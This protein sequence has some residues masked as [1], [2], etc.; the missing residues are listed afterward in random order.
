ML[1]CAKVSP[2]PRDQGILGNLRTEVYPEPPL[3]ERSQVAH[4]V[5]C[6]PTWEV[7]VHLFSQHHCIRQQR[8]SITHHAE[9]EITLSW[10]WCLTP[11]SQ[12]GKKTNWKERESPSPL[13]LS[14]LSHCSSKVMASWRNG[15]GGWL[16]LPPSLGF[17]PPPIRKLDQSDVTTLW[18]HK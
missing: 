5:T 4:W 2:Y 12:Q 1:P 9:G 8:E 16:P 11:N 18:I 13:L 10:V 17:R 6:C 15:T 7:S 3:L 14:C